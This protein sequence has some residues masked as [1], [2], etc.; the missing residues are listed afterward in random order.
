LATPSSAI[1]PTK[2]EAEAWIVAGAS[3]TSAEAP[4]TVEELLYA[5][6]GVGDNALHTR[7]E[8]THTTVNVQYYELLLKLP[9]GTAFTVVF[10]RSAIRVCDG[11]Q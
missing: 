11:N 9:H 5:G 6:F 10:H 4:M 2:K 8:V 3:Q 7:A 1:L